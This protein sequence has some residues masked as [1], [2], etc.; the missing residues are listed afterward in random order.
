M[1]IILL[2][3]KYVCLK[4]AI[5]QNIYEIRKYTGYTVAGSG[6][7]HFADRYYSKD[8]KLLTLQMTFKV[9]T[10][11][12]FSVVI[13]AKRHNLSHLY[14]G[15]P[16]SQLLLANDYLFYKVVFISEMAINQQHANKSATRQ[17]KGCH[18]EKNKLAL[19]IG[20]R[21]EWPKSKFNLI[22]G[23]TCKTTFF[24]PRLTKVV[25]FLNNDKKP[26]VVKKQSLIIQT[27]GRDTTLICL[28]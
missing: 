2:Y 8:S 4:L 17:L 3:C 20:L 5:I 28:F 24:H 25:R 12:V 13:V 23:L 6:M 9:A 26:N 11:F 1:Q 21:L 18:L 19:T 14:V 7:W 10:D 22:C 27:S 15:I 16:V